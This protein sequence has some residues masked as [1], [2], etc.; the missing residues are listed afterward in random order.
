M[1]FDGFSDNPIDFKA[2]MKKDK[3][4]FSVPLPLQ[5]ELTLGQTG[6]CKCLF[7]HIMVTRAS[8]NSTVG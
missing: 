8:Y 4:T 2:Y 3:V 1:Q 6:M 5:T 7:H